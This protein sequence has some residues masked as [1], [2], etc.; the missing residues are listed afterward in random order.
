[1]VLDR[2]NADRRGDMG[3]PGSWRS[4]GILPNIT[5]LMGGS[6]IGITLATVRALRS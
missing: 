6:F 4:R 1:M 2:L 3:L 5:T